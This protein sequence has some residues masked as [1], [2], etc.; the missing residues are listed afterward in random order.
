[1]QRI[2]KTDQRLQAVTIRI[3]GLSASLLKRIVNITSRIKRKLIMRFD[4][5]S[6]YTR[7]ERT[8]ECRY[9]ANSFTTIIKKKMTLIAAIFFH[10]ESLSLKC[11]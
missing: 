2:P 6:T 1:M 9:A 7:R 4:P 3:I 10:T 11:F 8:I 5:G